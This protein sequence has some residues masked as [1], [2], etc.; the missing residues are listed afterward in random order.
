MKLLLVAF[1]IVALGGGNA[2]MA[3]AQNDTVELPQNFE[4]GTNIVV[5]IIEKI[6]GA[7]SLVW[8]KTVIPVWTALWE[9]IIFPLGEKI[10]NTVLGFL[11]QQIEEKKP[12]LE[13]ELAREQEELVEEIESELNDT[14]T[15]FW[16]RFLSLFDIGDK[17]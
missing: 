4:E 16:E 14:K 15:S 2:P 6:P 7:F 10:W 5:K 13:Q 17:D 1:L 8:S 11:G 12:Q 3:F 9:N